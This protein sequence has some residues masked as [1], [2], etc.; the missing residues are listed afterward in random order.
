MTLRPL[1]QIEKDPAAVEPYGFDWTRYL[2]DLSPSETIVSSVY[3][4]TKYPTGISE[5]TLTFADVSIVTGS[6]KTQAR[7][8]GGTLNGR[9]VVTNT[10][11]TSGGTTDERSFKVLI[12]E[13]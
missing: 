9:Y 2:E 11:I 12:Q 4:V 3:T 8:L 6:K 7:L 5:P 1:G 10:I 13:Q